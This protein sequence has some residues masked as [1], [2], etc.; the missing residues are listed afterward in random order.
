MPD[1]V[2]PGAAELVSLPMFEK[3]RCVC[4]SVLRTAY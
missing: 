1:F 2:G 4:L 3:S